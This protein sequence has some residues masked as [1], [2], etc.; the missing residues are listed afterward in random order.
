MTHSAKLTQP[1]TLFDKTVLQPGTVLVTKGQPPASWARFS[2]VEQEKT[3]V[4]NPDEGD[5]DELRA[6]YEELAGEEPDKRWGA[7][8]LREELEKLADE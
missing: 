2:E 3:F 8:R 6:D 4:T 7:K 5:L 1:L